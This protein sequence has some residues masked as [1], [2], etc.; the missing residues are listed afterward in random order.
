MPVYR[1]AKS[2]QNQ[3]VILDFG[4]LKNA[5]QLGQTRPGPLRISFFWFVSLPNPKNKN[6]LKNH[7]LKPTPQLG[8]QVKK[9]LEVCVPIPAFPWQKN[10]HQQNELF[11]D[12]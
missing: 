1:M 8:P 4:G 5:Q 3:R 2:F 9:I 11:M 6:A 12:S 10:T 7:F